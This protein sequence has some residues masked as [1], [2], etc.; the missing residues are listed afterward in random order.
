MGDIIQRARSPR[1]GPETINNYNRDL[2]ES[3][4]D[5]VHHSRMKSRYPE[6]YRGQSSTYNQAM[7][8]C[9]QSYD[10]PGFRYYRYSNNTEPARVSHSF[11][12]NAA[13]PTAPD[14]GRL[15]TCP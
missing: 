14:S 7:G 3:I 6:T 8:R 13:P 11:V 10:S 1:P 2:V 9:Q 12:Q 15:S 5:T 4:A